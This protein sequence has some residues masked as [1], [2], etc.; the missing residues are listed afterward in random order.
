MAAKNILRILSVFFSC[1]LIISCTDDDNADGCVLPDI[2]PLTMEGEGGETVIDVGYDDFKI[3]KVLNITDGNETSIFG[4]AY[5]TDG[6][7]LRENKALYLDG[8]G[9]IETVWSDQGFRIVRDELSHLKVAVMENSRPEGFNFAIVLQA[10][11]E[12]K[13]IEIFQKKSQGY[14]FDKIE[15]S[16]KPD[17]RDSLF[18]V[19]GTTYQLNISPQEFKFSP[20]G[21]I[22]IIRRYYFESKDNNTFVWTNDNPP[23]IDIP[24]EIFDNQ[25]YYDSQKGIYNNKIVTTPHDYAETRETIWVPEGGIEFYTDIEFRHRIISYTVTLINNRTKTPKTV[26]GKWVETAPTGK[27]TIVK[28]K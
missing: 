6:Q 15:Y 22:D 4:E 11:D 18:I 27:Y 10:G 1:L 25:I 21:G 13:K 23:S 24:H 2:A 5:S 7:L 17:D 12:M 19:K 26:E 8:M 9:R 28:V 20:F 14:T 16:L 3:T